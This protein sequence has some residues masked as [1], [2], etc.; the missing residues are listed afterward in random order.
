MTHITAIDTNF[1]VSLSD[2]RARMALLNYF[3]SIQD[4]QAGTQAFEGLAP[5]R[6]PAAFVSIA[7]ESFEPNRYA[8]GGH[9]QRASATVSILFCL[10]ADRADDATNDEVEEVRKAVLAALRGYQPGG[11]LK[12]LESFRYQ[13]RLIAD[14]LIWGEWLFRTSYDLP[15][16]ATFNP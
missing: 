10:Q 16:V 8:S 1:G 11:A 15:T 2:I 7:N 14:G 12:A 9:G 13:I 4:I 3:T 5:F 6:P